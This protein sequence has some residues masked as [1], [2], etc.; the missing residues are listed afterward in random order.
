MYTGVQWTGT[1]TPGQTQTWFTWGWNPAKHVVWYVMPQ[2]PK[3]GAPELN[4]TVQVERGDPNG[5][6][7]WIT[8]KNLTS[9]TV[10]FEGR[11]AVLN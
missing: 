4:W 11:Y 9:V 10:V 8:V 7:Y 5:C 6:T 1:L 3:L 2:T